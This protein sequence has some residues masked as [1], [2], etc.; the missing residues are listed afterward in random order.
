VKE[1]GPVRL[2]VYDM[3][4]NEMQTLFE[5][6]QKRGTYDI[7]YDGTPFPGGSYIVRLQAGNVVKQKN[8][9]LQK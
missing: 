6:I 8:I 9:M 7:T 1:D 3:L 2:A 4:G 5:G